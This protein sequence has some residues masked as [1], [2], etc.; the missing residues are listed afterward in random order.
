MPTAKRN[1]EYFEIGLISP[2]EFISQTLTWQRKG[3][4]EFFIGIKRKTKKQAIQGW[5]LHYSEIKI[6][7]WGRRKIL[8]PATF[9]TQ[10]I[11]QSIKSNYGTVK[12]NG[13]P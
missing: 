8:S 11:L 3:K 2:E 10:K 7:K 12:W 6:R 9:T 13:S 5:R 4:H 1:G